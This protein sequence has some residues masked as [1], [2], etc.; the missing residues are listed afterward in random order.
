MK[1]KQAI[2]MQDAVT[3]KHPN[4]RRPLSVPIDKEKKEI[5]SKS[6]LDVKNCE[7]KT[8]PTSIIHL[9]V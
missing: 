3:I 2:G 4:T 1:V 6:I 8:N 5:D 9:E 7:L